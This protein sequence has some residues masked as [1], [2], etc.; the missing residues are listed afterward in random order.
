MQCTYSH[1]V[2]LNK[3]F[4]FNKEV[5]SQPQIVY[6]IVRRWESHKTL[7]RKREREREREIKRERERERERER[8]R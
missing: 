6:K 1:A 8:D 7:F 2:F 5:R 4:C 3:K